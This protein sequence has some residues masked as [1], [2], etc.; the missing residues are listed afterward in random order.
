M[1]TYLFCPE[2]IRDGQVNRQKQGRAWRAGEVRYQLHRRA[3]FLK[4]FVVHEMGSFG[5][6]DDDWIGVTRYLRAADGHLAPAQARSGGG[7]DN[8]DQARV[9]SSELGGCF[10][11]RGLELYVFIDDFKRHAGSL[12]DRG[13]C[14]TFATETV[15][16]EREKHSGSTAFGKTVSP[17]SA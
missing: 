13:T 2:L 9:T 11:G 10:S 17:A 16:D 14:S 7:T 12:S 8:V 6:R 5:V 15:K 3:L 1:F 4:C